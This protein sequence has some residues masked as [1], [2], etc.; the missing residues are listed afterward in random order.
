[1]KVVPAQPF[2]QHGGVFFLLVAVVRQDCPQLIVVRRV[3]ALVVPVDRLELFHQGNDRAVAVHGLRLEPL[4]GFM[5]SC[6]GFGQFSAAHDARHDPV[7]A[8][9]ADDGDAP[10]LHTGQCVVYCARAI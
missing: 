4:D 9:A 2:Q 1:L 6:A 8:D 5:Q 3:H 10:N 7:D